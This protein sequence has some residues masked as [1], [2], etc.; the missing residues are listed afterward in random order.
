VSAAR[1]PIRR[2]GALAAVVAVAAIVAGCLGDGVPA[3]V[4]PSPTRQPDPTPVTTTY[5]VGGSV[6]YEG[7]VLHIDRV[8]AVLDARGG[9]VEV[10][11]RVDNPNADTAELQATIFLQVDG[12]P[13]RPTR[14]SRIPP[15]PAKGQVASVITYEL[16]GVTS[17][18]DASVQVGEG[19]NHAAFMP[20]TAAGGPTVTLQP[21]PM[22]LTGT[23]TAEDL[24]ITLKEGLQRWDLP[25]WSQELQVDRQVIL[26]T[27]DATFEG[28]FTG[29]FPF[30][31]ATNVALRLPDG[32]DVRPRADGHYRPVELIGPGRTKRNLTTRFE[33]PA[34]V[35]GEVSFVVLAGD[36]EGL[37]PLVIPG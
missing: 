10:A 21:Q 36:E 8:T 26:V 22:P 23:G 5:D 15:I 19:P 13:I 25:D 9:P 2:L 29:G 24:R 16:Q 18:D 32:T 12:V 11:L 31:A 30:N 34:S 35:A 1:T 28:G 6:W 37:I 14:E 4:A 33:I 7:L 27:F 20:L 17:V 3:S